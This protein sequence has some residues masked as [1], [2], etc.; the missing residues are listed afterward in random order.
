MSGFIEGTSRTQ[1][2]LFP[3]CL[4]NYLSEEN[5]I[6]VID[7]FIDSLDLCDLGFKTVPANTG[8]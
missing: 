2:T 3:D 6:R 5:D 7:A 8:S 1:T 4:D